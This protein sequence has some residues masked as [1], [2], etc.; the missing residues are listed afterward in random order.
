MEL[1]EHR[2]PGAHP[3]R[4][5]RVLRLGLLATA[6]LTAIGA[7]T[8]GAQAI[9][10]A[11]SP[12]PGVGVA[13]DSTFALSNPGHHDR[14]DESFTVHQFGPLFAASVR[15][16]ATAES[17]Y[18]SADAPCRSVSLSFQIDTMA[19]TNIRLDTVNLSDAEND[20][21]DGCQTVAGAYQF[22]VSTPN[23]F[24]LSSS[25]Q[26]QLAA[27]HRQLDALSKSTASA[28]AIQE[29]ADALAAQVTAILKAA[30]ATAPPGPGVNGLTLL[31]PDVT[32]HKMFRHN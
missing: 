32:V 2:K 9:G 3:G 22:V 12:V 21:C 13:S 20:H 26:G 11:G 15:N 19:G 14:I 16:Q 6:S 25:A 7:I 28:A 8:G 5:R 1:N 17:A 27:I 30:A 18:C 4:R 10:Y 29:Q 31:V 24:T 23:P